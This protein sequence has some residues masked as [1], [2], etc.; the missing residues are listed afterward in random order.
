[1]TVS[2]MNIASLLDVFDYALV[3]IYG[4]ALDVFISGGCDTP[5]QKRLIAYLCP[6]FLVVQLLG[7]LTLGELAVK[8]IYPL[9]VHLPLVLILVLALKKPWGI[10]IVSTATA[11]LCCQPPRWGSMAVEALTHSAVAG[12]LVYIVLLSGS[13]YLF[14]RYFVAAAYG[15]MTSSPTALL[16]FGS[17]PCSYYIFDYAT[18]IYS[19]ALY[20]GIQALNEFLPTALIIFYVMFLTAYHAQSS[21]R[22]QAEM[23]STM[24]EAGLKQSQIEVDAL[25]RAEVQTAVYQ[26]D[27]RHH[28]NAIDGFLA[29]GKPQQA[30]EYIRKVRSDIERITPKRY[31]DNELVNLLCSSFA[32][33][34]QRMGVRL[35][36]DAKLPRELSVSDTELCAVL[37]NALENA[38]RAVSDQPEADRWVTLYCGVRLGKL[39]V[40][41]QN[42]CA[43]GLVMRDGLPVSER[44]GHGYGWPAAAS[45]R[46]P[47]GAADCASSAHGAASFPCSSCCRSKRRRKPKTDAGGCRGRGGLLFSSP[48]G[49]KLKKVQNMAVLSKIPVIQ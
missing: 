44:A 48:R 39:L 37:S 29:A 7:W 6:C 24:L 34:A 21:R 4:L 40:E 19:D 47:S 32:G 1:M 28:L 8:Q 10:A 18:T 45:R 30:E 14:R 15:A 22:A 31:C 36:V 33:K 2:D 12:N 16:L 3:L 20:S 5:R 35:E 9:I 46:S 42:P 26:H 43:E 41:I 17:L 38:L 13:F 27:M 49:K 23:Q 25:R 11:Y